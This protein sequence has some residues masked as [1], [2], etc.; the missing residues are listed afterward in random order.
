[1]RR[2]GWKQALASSAPQPNIDA[3]LSALDLGRLLDAV[4]SA[5][6]VGRGK[7]DPA[8]FLEAARR[9][10]LPPGRCVVVEDA[11]AGIEAARRAGMRSIGVLSPHHARLEA[12]VVVPSL[13]ALPTG[14]FEA[15]LGRG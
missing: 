2:D 4:V 9:L 1:L 15:L 11:P 10:G 6:E 5:D 8:I 14:A 12:D 13:G 7:P 3:A